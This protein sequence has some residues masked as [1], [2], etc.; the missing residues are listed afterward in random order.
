MRWDENQK[1]VGAQE[2]RG[3]RERKRER[4]REKDRPW[5][6]KSKITTNNSKDFH[7][8]MMID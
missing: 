5:T 4:E 1:S 3:E 6:K 2:L 8:F 7:K